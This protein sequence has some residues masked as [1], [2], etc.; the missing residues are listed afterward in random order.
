MFEGEI[1]Y[2]P[3]IGVEHIDE[4]YLNVLIFGPGRGEGIVVILPDGEVGAVDGCAW[5]NDAKSGDGDPVHLLVRAWMKKRGLR[6]SEQ[7][8]AFACITHL[9][10]DHYPGLAPLLKRYPPSYLWRTTAVTDRYLDVAEVTGLI[11]AQKLSGKREQLRL[12]VATLDAFSRE[13]TTGTVEATL[14][15]GG[16]LIQVSIG[17]G[18][19]VDIIPAGPPRRAVQA[20]HTAIHER[21]PLPDPN[22][23]SGALCLRWGRAAVLLAGDLLAFNIPRPNRRWLAALQGEAAQP[24]NRAGPARQCSPSRI[25]GRAR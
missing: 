23:A 21:R 3:Q 15:S 11:D 14:D 10:D 8:L 12:T 9:H 1:A 22:A 18:A 24:R 2:E 25:A 13:H 17:E 4:G 6:R 20:V 16:E 5:P 19:W 7:R